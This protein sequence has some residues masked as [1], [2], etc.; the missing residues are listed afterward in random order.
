M[1]KEWQHIDTAPK[2][3]TTIEVAHDNEGEETS[4]AFWSDRPVCMLGERCGGFPPGWATAPEQNTDN[5]LPLSEV[6]MWRPIQ[7]TNQ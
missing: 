6:I 2:D 3:G 7:T 4:F 1:T 5:N